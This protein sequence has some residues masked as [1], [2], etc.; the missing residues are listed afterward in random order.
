MGQRPE[1]VNGGWGEWG[2][3]SECSRTCG[4]GVQIAERDCNNPVPKHK[5]RYC[6]GDR[7]KVQICNTKVS[8]YYLQYLGAVF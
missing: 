1:A 5:G 8:Y 6:L 7:K 4:G 3:F 2:K